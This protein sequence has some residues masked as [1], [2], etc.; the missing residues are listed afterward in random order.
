MDCKPVMFLW[1]GSS[2]PEYAMR[3]IFP[4][5]HSSVHRIHVC[6]TGVY[7]KKQQAQKIILVRYKNRR[8]SGARM[9]R[10]QKILCPEQRPLY[11]S[12]A[13]RHRR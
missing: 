4:V 3:Y 1:A 12:N 2:L 5:R 6:A 8:S 7:S 13:K 10:V 9:E 11:A